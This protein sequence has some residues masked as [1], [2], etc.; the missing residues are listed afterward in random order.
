MDNLF[1]TVAVISN[2]S[3][4]YFFT[5]LQDTLVLQITYNE[6]SFFINTVMQQ[7]RSINRKRNTVLSTTFELFLY[8]ACDVTDAKDAYKEVRTHF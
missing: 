6:I 5:S 2:Y 4:S 8:P 3:E 1:V 7:L